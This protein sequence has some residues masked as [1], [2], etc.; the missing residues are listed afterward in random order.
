[1]KKPWQKNLETILGVLIG[2]A[3][4]AFT[5]AAFMVPHGIIMGG[6]TGIGLTISHYLPIQ[7]S[8]I[9][10]AVNACLFLLGAVTLGKK[11]VITTIA[12]T[13]L[14]PACLTVMQAIPGI[15]RLTDNIM[16]ATLYGGALLGLGVGMIV[17][18]GSSTG[19]TD[20]LALVFNKWF[21][22][23]VAVLMYI[24]DFAVLGAQAVFSD[25][26]QIMYGILALVIETFVLNRVMLMGQSQIQL[27][28]ISEKYEE[29]RERM[30]KEQNVGVTMVHVETGYGKENKKAV[31]CVIHNRKLYA[32]N[33]MIH[34]I[35]EKAFI[36]ISQI[37]E[38]K[39]RGFTLE[40]ESYSEAGE[41]KKES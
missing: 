19:G 14:Y 17:R 31:L 23:S 32:T 3:L 26:E 12:S 1:M 11:F 13:F 36:T 10:L 21:H 4:L 40:R 22:V 2:N 34:A 8:L 37:N 5:V 25:S 39:G 18:V 38:V 30:L 15:T 33:E 28:V 24:V 41:A 16:L 29:I 35:D 20:I 7:L 27:F 6:A 9:I